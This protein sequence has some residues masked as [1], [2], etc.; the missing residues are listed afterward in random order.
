MAGA[1][2][3]ALCHCLFVLRNCLSGQRRTIFVNQ[4]QT[5]DN[6]GQEQE[7]APSATIP[8]NSTLQVIITSKDTRESKQDVCAVCLNEFKEGD[9]VRVLSECTH[10]F[11]VL[12]IDK[13]LNSHHNCPLCRA[14][15]IPPSDH[16]IITRPNPSGVPLPEV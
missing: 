15:T 10:I 1:I 16:L 12:C 9:G 7:H 14:D 11:H 5:T 2:V 13:W 3:V 4:R 8:S 6:I